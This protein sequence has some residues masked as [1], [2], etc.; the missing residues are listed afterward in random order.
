MPAKVIRSRILITFDR[1]PVK[2][3]AIA[4]P[5]P[6]MINPAGTIAFGAADGHLYV[7]PCHRCNED[8]FA[9]CESR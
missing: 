1:M 2:R 8:T 4:M 9:G 3:A 6:K 7:A 5:F